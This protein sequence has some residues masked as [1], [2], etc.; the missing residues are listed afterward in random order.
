MM[1]NELLQQ[2]EAKVEQTVPPDQQSAYQRI[3]VA[4]M[5]VLYS[6]QTH[7]AII[8]GLKDSKEPLVDAAK[9]AVGLVMTLYRE[10]KGTMPV[11]A[12]IPASMTLLL[13]A[14]DYLDSTGILAIGKPEIETATRAFMDTLMPQLGMTPD[15]TKQMLGQFQGVVKDQ[16]KM[17][18]YKQQMGGG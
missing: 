3:V 11:K 7:D 2:A 12:M 6:K 1:K 4:G 13:Q 10:S 8:V 18:A 17:Q 14:L 15:R 9:G 16:G 5:K